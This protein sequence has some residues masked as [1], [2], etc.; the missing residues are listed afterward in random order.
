MIHKVITIIALVLAIVGACGFLLTGACE[1]DTSFTGGLIKAAACAL[2][3][4]TGIVTLVAESDAQ[5]AKR[6]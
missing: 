2:I 4:I 6:S 5:T 3:C 1:S